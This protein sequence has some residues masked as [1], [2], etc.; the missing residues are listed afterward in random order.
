MSYYYT[1]NFIQNQQQYIPNTPYF[2]KNTE[3]YERLPYLCTYKPLFVG[4]YSLFV[5]SM[6][7]LS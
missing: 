1:M 4:L 3:N 6:S 2:S 7:H 5:F